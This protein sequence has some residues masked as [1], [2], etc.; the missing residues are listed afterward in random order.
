MLISRFGLKVPDSLFQALA[1]GAGAL[2]TTGAGGTTGAK[3]GADT[4]VLDNFKTCPI[5]IMFEER[6]F[7]VFSVSTL[8]AVFLEIL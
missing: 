8:M 1:T 2:V 6:P 7:R 5:A 3:I 4:A